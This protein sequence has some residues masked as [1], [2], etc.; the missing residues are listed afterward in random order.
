MICVFES[1]SL[2]GLLIRRSKADPV[3]F[4][5]WAA[6]AESI[7]PAT[8]TGAGLG[9][10]SVAGTVTVPERCKPRRGRDVT[11][12]GKAARAGRRNTVATVTT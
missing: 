12:P 3:C 11:Q 1:G 2:A 9:L 10:E 8:V 4:E 6:A 5:S 7:D